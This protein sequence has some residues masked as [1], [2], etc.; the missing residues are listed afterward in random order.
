M[1]IQAL[2]EPA[3]PRRRLIPQA[4]VLV[5]DGHKL[6]CLTLEGELRNLETGEAR[7]LIQQHMPIVCNGLQLAARLGME[8]FHSYDVLELFAF[9]RPGKF[10]VPTPRGIARA[11]NLFEPE[12]PED[13][14]LGLRDSIRHL[15]VDLTAPGREEKSD[16]AALAAMMGLMGVVNIEQGGWPWTPTILAALGRT[17]TPPTRSDIK[18]AMRIWD[19]LP[20]WSMHGPEPAPSHHG[21]E[22]AEVSARLDKLLQKQH[23]EHRAEQHQY[24]EALSAAFAPNDEPESPHTVLAEAGT[25]VG[26]T[27]GYLAPATVWAEKN[28][29]AVWISTFTRNLQRQV[30]AELDRLYDDPVT[31][32]R[33]VV[34]RK[35]RENYLCLLNLEDTTQAPSIA[36]NDL[37]AIALGLMLRW[38]AVTEDGDL[39]GKDFPGWLN[40]LLG[41]SRVY[42]FADR[43]G[44]CIYSAC[45]HFNKCF[46]EKS[47]RKAKR[48]DIVIAN[49]A[50]VMQQVVMAGPDSALPGRYIFDEGHHLFE[51]ADG[52]FDLQ[53]NGTW[54]SDLRRWLLGTESEKRSRARGAKRRL[55]DL[56]TDNEAAGKDL[57]ALMQA[58]QCLP[59]PS[60]RQ[61]LR[62]GTPK[63][64]TEVFL[65]LCR[66]QVL[67]RNP[68][69]NGFYS[70]ETGVQPPIPDLLEAAAALSKKLNEVRRPIASLVKHLQDRLAD[71]AEALDTE[72]RE[73]IHFAISSLN[74]RARNVLGGWIDM[75]EALKTATPP[76]CVDWL[77]IARIDGRDD[78]VGF[79]RYYVDPAKVFAEQLK[80]QTQGVVV[81]SATLRDVSDEDPQGWASALTRTGVKHMSP[82]HF[83][84][85]SSPFNYKTQTRVIVV[86]DVKKDDPKEMAAAY[87]E[88]FLASGGGALGIFTA[89]QRLKAVHEKLMPAL[90]NKGIHLYAQHVDPLDISTLIDIFREEENACLLGTDA[91]RDGIDVPGRSLRLV[92]YDRVPW[93]KPTILHKARRS[94]FGKSYDDM[95]TRF[96]LKQAYGRLI[97]R[98]DDKGIFVLLDGALPSRLATAFPE[99]VAVER[100]GLAEAIKATKEFLA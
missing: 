50:L 55:E 27:L 36:T 39:A 22:P 78:D 41:R 67:A 73:R 19:K 82:P 84:Q 38:A 17:E 23:K 49:H 89:V 26:K 96:K 4:P 2:K 46:I 6:F 100:V 99:G 51:A 70:L 11:L 92:V 68:E 60:W 65:S 88:L 45:T 42:N 79:Y 47:V 66:Q 53:L 44:E 20:E 3:I 57:D 61:R 7:L 94:Y 97:R 16:P 31:K 32:S 85:V 69:Q 33:K 77:E 48:A 63:G 91:T 59:A 29:G 80:P 34:T 40:S 21:I 93:P 86:G 9:I 43:R 74:F 72:M 56:V 81:T 98:A 13:Q 95:L 35:G 83:F 24:A 14:C 37:N 18:T 15:L 8:R 54:T 76:E 25:G 64:V 90:E 12:T 5:M 28:E 71:E 87:R 58:A 10:A 1:T 75:L 52:A 30:E 62:D